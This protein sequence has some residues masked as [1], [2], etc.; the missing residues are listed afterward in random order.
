MVTHQGPLFDLSSYEALNRI[1]PGPTSY[2]FYFGVDTIMNGTI[3]MGSMIYDSVMVEV[4][5]VE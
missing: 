1:L 2:T 4:L 5:P 3:D